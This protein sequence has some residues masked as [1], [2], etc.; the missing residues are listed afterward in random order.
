[1]CRINAQM[2]TV[3]PTMKREA[4]SRLTLADLQSREPEYERIPAI[5]RRFSVSRPFVFE[6]FHKGV[7]SIHVRKAGCEKGIRLVSV[8][9]MRAYLESFGEGV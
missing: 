8:A 4:L 1:M 9:S 5:C 7:K 2:S 6:S 3:S